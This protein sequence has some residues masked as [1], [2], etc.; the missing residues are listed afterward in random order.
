M[1]VRRN[2]EL[3]T[4]WGLQPASRPLQQPSP[5]GLPPAVGRGEDKFQPGGLRPHDLGMLQKGGP[6]LTALPP[7]L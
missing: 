2:W 4:N 1:V 7:T 3:C 5:K 6:V